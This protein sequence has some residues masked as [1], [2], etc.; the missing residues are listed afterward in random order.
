MLYTPSAEIENKKAKTIKKLFLRVFLTCWFF[1]LNASYLRLQSVDNEPSSAA[2]KFGITCR[3]LC[4]LFGVFYV[5]CLISNPLPI[6]F[7]IHRPW[8]SNHQYCTL[9]SRYHPVQSGWQAPLVLQSSRRPN[10]LVVT[11]IVDLPCCFSG[12]FP[13]SIWDLRDLRWP[14]SPRQPYWPEMSPRL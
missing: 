7:G 6:V 1:I 4:I 8:L 3:V 10:S 11:P 12:P 2:P 5:A 13:L 9:V 14:R